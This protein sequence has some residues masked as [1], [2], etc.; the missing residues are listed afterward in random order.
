MPKYRVTKTYLRMA[1]YEATM[2][3]E[4]AD[5]AEAVDKSMSSDAWS[6]TQVGRSDR[7]DE[8][9]SAT[10]VP[11]YTPGVLSGSVAARRPLKQNRC[12]SRRPTVKTKKL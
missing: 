7:F 4:A 12:S 1:R 5:D 9:L 8:D 2:V 11:D 10:E 3:V 6:E